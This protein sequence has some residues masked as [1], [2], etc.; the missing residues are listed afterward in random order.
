[1]ANAFI[2]PLS[3]VVI[4]DINNQVF[5]AYQHLKAVSQIEKEYSIDRVRIHQLVNEGRIPGA[6]K[7]ANAWY[8]D[9]THAESFFDAYAD[10]AYERHVKQLSRLY[11][12]KIYT[13]IK[14]V[15][16]NVDTGFCYT[17]PF[18]DNVYVMPAEYLSDLY[19]YAEKI[20]EWRY[21]SGY[22]FK[23]QG[24]EVSQQQYLNNVYAS[25]KASEKIYEKRSR[26]V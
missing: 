21:N 4:E 13:Y 23:V 1:M 6:V 16:S 19:S 17:D 22:V 25:L 18:D 9:M 12:P 7:L 5:F 24:E 20:A 3:K 11:Q 14:E 10:W 2:Y 15:Q 26:E 8:F